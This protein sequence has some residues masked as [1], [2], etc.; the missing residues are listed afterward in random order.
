MLWVTTQQDLITEE[1][2]VR[3]HDS[4]LRSNITPEEIAAQAIENEVYRGKDEA[5]ADQLHTLMK[6]WFYRCQMSG[7][8]LE[9]EAWRKWM[10]ERRKSVDFTSHPELVNMGPSDLDSLNAKKE[11]E[12]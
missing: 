11:K 1:W 2:V 6:R 4:K 3:V 12:P 8:L 5:R 7:V 10:S 9:R